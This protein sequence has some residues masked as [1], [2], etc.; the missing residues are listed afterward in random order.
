VYLRYLGLPF[1][2]SRPS[3]G[4]GPLTFAFTPGPA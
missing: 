2:R 4:G 3:H 1:R